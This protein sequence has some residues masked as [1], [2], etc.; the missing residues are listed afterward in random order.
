[1]DI[2]PLI[3]PL[4][5][6]DFLIL[7]DDATVSQLIGKLKQYEKHSAIVFRNHKYLGLVEKKRLLRTRLDAAEAK[8]G[9][10]VQKAPTLNED[11]EVIETAY[12]LFQSNLDFA[13]V[14]KNKAIIGVVEGVDVALAALQLP[15]IQK[16]LVSDIKLVKPSKVAKD[17]PISRAI[18]VM[19]DE[20]IDHVP[21][22]DL[23]KLFGI[24][25]YKDLLRR[26]L[27]WTPY[28][29]YS[30]RFNKMAGNKVV[31]AEMPSLAAL[32][33]GTFCTKDNLL[34]TRPGAFLRDALAVMKKNNVHDLIVQ[35]GDILVG[36]LSVKNVLRRIGSL[37]IPQNFN[38]QFIGLNQLH[39]EPQQKDN[40]QKICSHE[41]FKLQ[42]K[43][44]NEFVLVVHLK[45]YESGGTGK[46]EPG[47]D[48]GKR[49]KAERLEERGKQHK[50]SVHIRMEFP[51][52]ILTVSQDDWEIEAALH[53]TFDNAQNALEKKFKSYAVR[54]ARKKGW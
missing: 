47:R 46:K 49:S 7:Q 8:L 42:R 17:D 25:S 37:K 13:P 44:K 4:I 35:Q 2:K 51:G 41:A 31:E 33:V 34:I 38:I 9:K 6:P 30:T 53:K 19:H 15:E 45:E 39:L 32:P 1:M 18:E 11:A 36:L 24:L 3:K 26:Y 23:G 20:H 40:V 10:Y 43:I 21:V 28:R 14:E 54:G 16:L 12:Q 50:Y 27:G 5:K 29:D 48:K 52:Q 22:Y